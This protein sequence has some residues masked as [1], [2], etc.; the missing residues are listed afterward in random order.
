MLD[1]FS[2]LVDSSVDP[3]RSSATRTSPASIPVRVA[4]PGGDLDEACSRAATSARCSGHRPDV[5][6]A[7]RRRARRHDR[8]ARHRRRPRRAVP[9]RPR[10]A[11]ASTSSAATPS[12][13]A[14]AQP[15]R[16][17]AGRAA[18]HADGRPARRRAAG[19][20][21]LAGVATGA[22]V[23]PIRVAGWQPDALGHW[24][25]YAPQR[26]ADRRARARG[27]PERRRRRARRGAH[28][29]RRARRAVRR[30]RRR[31]RGA[32]RRRA[33][34]RS[35]RSSS[36]RPGNDGTAGA[37]Y[38]DIAGPGG[39][40]A[41]L[42]VG[43]VDTRDAAP[44]ARASSCARGSTTLLDGTTPRRRRGA[45]RA[46][47][48]DLQRSPC[49][50]ARS[51]ATRRT[52]P[53]LTDFFTR[54]GR[55]PRRRPR[56]ARAR[57]AR[58]RCPPPRGPP[59][60]ARRP[61]CSTAA[62]RRCPPA[63]SASTSRS[64]V[65][66]V[67]VPT[68]AAR[69]RA[70]AASRRGSPS[71]SRSARRAR[72][73]NSASSGRVAAF[74][75]PGLAFD[76]AREARPRRAR[77]RARDLRSRR[78]RRRL[79]ALRHGQR[80]ER[81]R[82][83]G[84]GRGGAARAGAP[85]ARRR[86]AQRACSSAT[87]RAS[88]GEPVTAQ[89]SG[90]VDVGAAAAGEVAASPR[91]AR[92]RS[93][94]RRRLARAS[95]RSRSRTSRRDRCALTLG[96]RTQDEGAAAVDF[97]LSPGA[98][99]R[100]GTGKS[101]ARARCVRSRRR[102]RSARR[103]ADGAVVVGVQGGGG[104]RIPWAI[105]FGP[106]ARRPDRRARRCRRGRSRASDT[107]PALL[108]VDAGRVLD[109]RGPIRDPAGRAARRRPLARRR[110]TGRDARAAPRRAARPLHVRAHRPRA[111]AASALAPGDVRGPRSSP[112]RSQPGAPSRGS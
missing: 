68:G 105:A 82:R 52:A 72:A 36:R 58:R 27:R 32:R 85:V 21:G 95:R 54:D 14:A 37:G 44:T 24:A 26:P 79:A 29:A 15:G 34:S 30:L 9:A 63:G 67:S 111:R 96:V 64:R 61:C 83:D 60:P 19:P 33:R 87:A 18:R 76:G 110:H 92:A 22:S 51:A 41:A 98:G 84:R 16:P 55:Q 112:T 12:A 46:R 7:G 66:V 25:I 20:S 45:A 97:T 101:V 99:R 65:P 53:R 6:A 88:A 94:D 81:G 109:G 89:G 93:L 10:A 4:Y 90:L 28:R 49:R 91:D 1:G 3:A 73:S 103:P 86:R 11:R 80:L 106:R 17:D 56:G 2:A 5:A 43:A 100:S 8:A 39:A 74:S 102:R 78:E 59:R 104:I 47:A 50:A 38:G 75:S 48:L 42:T 35:T 77:R 57:S 62:G 71:P 23:L 70:R 40:P 107:K 69:A 31:A 13:L 108:A